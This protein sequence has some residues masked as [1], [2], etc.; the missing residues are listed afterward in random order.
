MRPATACGCCDHS[1][2]RITIGARA[3]SK[4][5]VRVVAL[6]LG[7]LVLA[8]S[9]FAQ[10][11]AGTAPPR[12]PFRIS[13][14]SF[15]VEEA[16]NQEAGIFQNIFGATRIDGQWA[17]TFTQ[18]WPV[19]VTDPPALLHGRLAEA[20]PPPVS[21]T[22]FS[23][24]AT[25]HPGGARPAGVLAAAERRSPDRT[26]GPRSRQRIVRAAGQP[27][28][29]QAVRRLATALERRPDVAAARASAIR[30][31]EARRTRASVCSRRSSPPA[32]STGCAPC[33]T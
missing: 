25:R 5:L 3:A 12:D 10:A 8:G 6:M 30:P 17:A 33:A 15:L 21:A 16:F 28:G 29:Q 1:E 31:C 14:N 23:T 11:P 32:A 22:H 4:V 9:A 19:V 2:R 20:T 13:D 26:T 24:T 18:E 7:V 27:A